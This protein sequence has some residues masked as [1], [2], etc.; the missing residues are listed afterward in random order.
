MPLSRSSPSSFWPILV[1][2]DISNQV[3]IVGLFY[4]QKKPNNANEFLQQFVEKLIPLVQTGYYSDLFNCNIKVN[5]KAMI[6]D[7]PAKSFI[8][9]IKGHNGYSSCTKCTIYGDY[10]NSRMCFPYEKRSSALRTDEEFVRQTDSDYHQGEP[11][12]LRSV[13]N[14]GL[15]SNIALDYMHLICLGVVKK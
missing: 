2:D 11:T 10:V 4:D 15:V 5:I 9:N 3:H 8:L 12:I 14:L 1:S 13:P 7:A 6:C